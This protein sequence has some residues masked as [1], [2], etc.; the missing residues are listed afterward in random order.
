MPDKAVGVGKAVPASLVTAPNPYRLILK[1]TGFGPSFDSNG[2][3]TS[4]VKY[5]SR[6]V[7]AALTRLGPSV[8]GVSEY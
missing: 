7:G 4:D 5:D 8:V 2:G 6:W 3:G 1:V